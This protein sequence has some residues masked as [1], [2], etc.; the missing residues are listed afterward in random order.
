MRIARDAQRDARTT[1]RLSRL[2]ADD[3]AVAVEGREALGE[4]ERVGGDAVRRAPLGRLGE[5][6][7][8]REQQLD[9]RALGRVQRLRAARRRAGG[10][11]AACDAL[12]ARPCASIEAIRACAYCT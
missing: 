5:L 6:A 1:R 7:G 4:L 10:A 12:G 9:Q 8:E 11:S 3:A 2:G